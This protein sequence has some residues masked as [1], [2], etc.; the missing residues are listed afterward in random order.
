[1]GLNKI[2]FNLNGKMYDSDQ[3]VIRFKAIEILKDKGWYDLKKFKTYDDYVTFYRIKQE[4]PVV[5]SKLY[6]EEEFKLLKEVFEEG[7]QI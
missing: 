5:W 1:M 3:I 4:I 2:N 7:R 6:K